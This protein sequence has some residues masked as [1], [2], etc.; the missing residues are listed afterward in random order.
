LRLHQAISWC[1]EPLEGHMA[2][3]AMLAWR[4][5]HRDWGIL[6]RRL[7]ILLGGE[8]PAWILLLAGALHDAGKAPRCY[9]ERALERCKLG[10]D[11]SFG[12]HEYLS[13]YTGMALA[14]TLAGKGEA[15]RHARVPLYAAAAAALLHHHGMSERVKPVREARERLL[16][17]GCLEADGRPR[18]LRLMALLVASACRLLEEMGPAGVPRGSITSCREAAE[19]GGAAVGDVE[20]ASVWGLMRDFL[21]R[22]KLG[23]LRG[24]GEVRAFRAMTSFLAGAVSLA[25]TI[26]ASLCRRGTLGG[27]AARVLAENARMQSVLNEV[28]RDVLELCGGG[29]S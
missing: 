19:I 21:G 23:V 25:D 16:G 1:G 24:S 8:P 10:G 22:A 6:R 18:E 7:A 20:P 28:R 11:P 4:L 2:A 9:Q 14:M 26:A 17:L 13:G 3:T 15:P 27:Y 12:L 5:Y 29:E